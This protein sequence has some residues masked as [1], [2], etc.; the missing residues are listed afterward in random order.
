MFS[1][2]LCVTERA[3]GQEVRSLSEIRLAPTHAAAETITARTETKPCFIHE[4]NGNSSSSSSVILEVY[5]LR[6][7][8]RVR[9]EKKKKTRRKHEKINEHHP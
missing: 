8:L 6:P 5:N 3:A 7:R 2:A 1:R 4:M 9:K